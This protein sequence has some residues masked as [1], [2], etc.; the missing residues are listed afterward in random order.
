MHVCADFDECRATV[1]RRAGFCVELRDAELA[2]DSPTTDPNQLDA[3]AETF[4]S[5][6][7]TYCSPSSCTNSTQSTITAEPPVVGVLRHA[8]LAPQRGGNLSSSWVRS[9][10]S[11]R[12]RR[13]RGAQHCGPKDRCVVGSIDNGPT[14]R[15]ALSF[16]KKRPLKWPWPSDHPRWAGIWRPTSHRRAKPERLDRFGQVPV[17]RGT[18]E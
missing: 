13:S 2:R 15:G 14:S 5:A 12:R 3:T 6:P 9:R 11:Q 4:P 7:A 16:H 8:A 1:H 17:R 18:S 10:P